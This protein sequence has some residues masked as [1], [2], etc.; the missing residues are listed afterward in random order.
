MKERMPADR[1]MESGRDPLPKGKRETT[2]ASDEHEQES[3][4]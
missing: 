2:E 1:P 3:G 4:D